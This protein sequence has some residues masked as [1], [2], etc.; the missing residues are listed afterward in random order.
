MA[1]FLFVNNALNGTGGPRVILNL[2]QALLEKGHNVSIVVDRVDNIDFEIDDNISVY[3]WC[4]FGV[5]QIDLT[6]S[7]CNTSIHPLSKVVKGTGSSFLKRMLRSLRDIRYSLFSPIFAYTLKK[8]TIVNEID[9][10]ANSN[11][12]IGVERQFFCSKLIKNYFVSYHNS[13]GEVFSRR[14]Y[15]EIVSKRKV[16]N[17]LDY[18]CVS[19]AIK[20]ELNELGFS[21]IVREVIYNGFDFDEVRRLAMLEN[22]SSNKPYILSISTLSE[23]KRVDRIIRAYSLMEINNTFDLV[24]LGEGH[25]KEELNELCISLGIEENVK[26]LG[27]QSNP[28]IY[29]S[30]S[31]GLVLASD[32]EGLPTVI[33]ESLILGTPVISTNCPTGPSEILSTWG[34]EALVE[35]NY[36]EQIIYDIASKM[37]KIL[38]AKLSVEYVIEHSDLD[39][40]QKNNVIVKWQSLCLN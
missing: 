11:I 12:Y 10:V 37:S 9:V 21:S 4:L 39:R 26:F 28:Y 3:Q 25:L 5:K 7:E 2:A 32:S 27:F 15:F 24:I 23:R 40:F 30:S 34:D 33:I 16:L 36:E 19:S 13:P 38:D 22:K 17:K 1:N 29:L 31:S 35:M 6:E 18:V 14:D 20:D 8:F